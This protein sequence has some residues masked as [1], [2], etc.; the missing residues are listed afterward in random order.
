MSQKIGTFRFRKGDIWWA[1]IPAFYGG[2][3]SP[4]P[5][6][7]VQNTNDI[8]HWDDS[9]SIAVATITAARVATDESNYGIDIAIEEGILSKIFVDQI[10]NIRIYQFNDYIGFISESDYSE[11]IEKVIKRMFIGEAKKYRYFGENS[12]PKSKSSVEAFTKIRCDI[13]DSE[14]VEKN[15]IYNDYKGYMIRLHLEKDKLGFKAFGH[16]LENL[17]GVTLIG[18]FYRGIAL[19]PF[20]SAAASTTQPTAV[21]PIPTNKIAHQHSSERINDIKNILLPQTETEQELEYGSTDNI[22]NKNGQ[23]LDDDTKRKLEIVNCYRRKKHD[24]LEAK[25][26]IKLKD[27]ELLAEQY[28]TELK[29][30]KIV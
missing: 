15:I 28:L 17:Y 4:R 22:C 29:E 19:K 11:N 23:E 18:N 12:N 26:N 8:N 9:A 10:V 7:I 24:V 6:V 20:V 2:V 13:S 14:K 16:M 3:N 5:V 21:A 27:Q 25:Y 1:E 30:R